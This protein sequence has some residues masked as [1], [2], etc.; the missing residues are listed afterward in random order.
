MSG[1]A[2]APGVIVTASNPATGTDPTLIAEVAADTVD[3]TVYPQGRAVITVLVAGEHAASSGLGDPSA[4]LNSCQWGSRLSVLHRVLG[5][6][7]R[8][9][10]HHP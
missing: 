2:G 3:S 8:R 6:R 1:L 4:Y 7:A 10:E 5:P 9:L